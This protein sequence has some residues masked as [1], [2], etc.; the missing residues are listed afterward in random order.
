MVYV[1]SSVPIIFP[2][3]NLKRSDKVL[4][5]SYKGIIWSNIIYDFLRPTGPLITVD[6]MHILAD[7]TANV[8]A[9][10]NDKMTEICLNRIPRLATF[11]AFA[12]CPKSASSIFSASSTRSSPTTFLW[13]WAAFVNITVYLFCCFEKF[14]STIRFAT[15]TGFF[16]FRNKYFHQKTHWDRTKL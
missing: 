6:C 16:S 2:G 13:Y 12:H 3:W 8:V 11:F 7:R 5:R 10:V 15:L 4:T 1:S 9:N 14:S